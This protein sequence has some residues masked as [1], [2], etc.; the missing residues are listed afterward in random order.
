MACHSCHNRACCNP[1]HIREGTAKENT[2]DMLDANRQAPKELTIRRGENHGMSKLTNAQVTEIR[3]L[4]GSESVHHIARQ[5]KVSPSVV[6]NIHLRKTW[7]H[8]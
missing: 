3:R 7:I 5:F 4:Q 2:K 6:S 1:E 8:I